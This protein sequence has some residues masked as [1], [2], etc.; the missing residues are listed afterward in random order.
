MIVTESL[1]PRP[2]INHRG[3][4]TK[5]L[6]PERGGYRS[7]VEYCENDAPL[8]RRYVYGIMFGLVNYPV[9]LQDFHFLGDGNRLGAVSDLQP[10]VNV[11]DVRF[12]CVQRDK[13][14]IG[15]FLVGHA[16]RHQAQHFQFTIAEWI[17]A[18]SRLA[19]GS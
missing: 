1:P 5:A 15:D 8:G 7:T 17:L 3:M 18:V 13:Q 6:R 16:A 9:Y 4:F 2:A 11:L 10:G 14:F 12:D 19:N